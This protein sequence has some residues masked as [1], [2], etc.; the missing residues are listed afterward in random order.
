MLRILLVGDDRTV[1]EHLSAQPEMP[2]FEF[3]LAAGPLDA[4]GR[5]RQHAYA[6]VFTPPQ[7]CMDEDLALLAELQRARPGIRV[8][9]LAPEADRDE[10]ISAMRGKAFACFTA[11]FDWP[12]IASIVRSALAEDHWRES[13]EVVSATPDWIALR[14]ESRL[15]T[16]ERVVQFMRELAADQPH[17]R[18]D[19][20]MFA[21]REVLLNAMEHG[22]GFNPEQV[23]EVSAIRTQRAIVYYFRDPGEGFRRDDLKRATPSNAPPDVISTAEFRAES[24]LRPGG[25]GMLIV[26]HLVDEV[27]YNES[28]NQVILVKHT[29]RA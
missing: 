2:P 7:T 3:D 25:F 20:L 11:P 14:V 29:D 26:R 21:F 22:G 13:I 17:D 28:G 16:A 24:G 6:L 15:L 4:V 8:I 1:F 18:R 23:V 27:I 9:L 19:D 5:V 10:V 12:E